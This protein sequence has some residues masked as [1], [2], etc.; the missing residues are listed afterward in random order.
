MLEMNSAVFV[1]FCD[2]TAAASIWEGQNVFGTLIFLI[3]ILIYLFSA[4]VWSADWRAAKA[5]V[6]KIKHC[7]P[8][9]SQGEVMT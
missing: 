7:S 2:P 6:V 9:P 1:Y 3:S 4:V 5:I 8:G